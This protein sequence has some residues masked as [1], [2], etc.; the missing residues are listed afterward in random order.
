MVNDRF[1]IHSS[2]LAAAVLWLVGCAGP[3]GG[4][5]DAAPASAPEPVVTSVVAPVAEKRD[6]AVA[7][8]FGV[9]ND[10][11]YWLRDD[12]RKDPAVLK[13]LRA[14]NAYADAWFN[15][16]APLR[17]AL[18]NE[19]KAR[20]QEDDASVPVKDH[21]WWYYRRFAAGQQYGIYAR[22]RGTM[23]S[24]EQVLVD[25]NARAAGK[26]FWQLGDFAVS[27]DGRWLAVAEDTVG[28]RQYTL[29]F[30]DL[31]ED[32]WLDET[33][34]NVDPALAFASDNTT[35][36]YVLKDPVTLLPYRVMRHRL[37]TPVT[38]DTEVW[39]ERDNTFY[40]T[41]YKTKSER[42]LIIYLSSTQSTEVRFVDADQPDQ[43]PQVFMARQPDHEY[44]LDHIGDEFIVRSNWQAPNFRL[45]R[46]PVGS[47]SNPLEWR[48]LLPHRAD[49]LVEGFELFADRIA[50]SERSGGL[51]KIR[52]MPLSG[53]GMG[54]LLAAEEPTYT[55]DLDHTPDLK[56]GKL[57][58]T[59]TSL[60][61]P[62]TVYELDFASGAR[63]LLKRDPVVGSFKPEDYASEY[64]MVPARDGVQIPVSLVYRK[65][66]QR[67]G[68]HPLLQHAYGSYG[69]SRDP[70]FNAN[71]L[72]LLDRGFGFA[73]A[74]IRGGQELGRQWYENGRQLKK[75]NTFNDFV[76]V[77]DYLRKH[78]Y[79]ANDQLYAQGGSAGGLL[80]GAI[81]NQ[82]PDRYRGII[83]NVPFVDV[84]TTM[85]DESI[86]LTTGEFDE[87][88]NPKIK[89]FH[90][91]MLAYSP[92]DQVKAQDYPALYVTTGLWDSQ[93]QY[94]E[95]AKW[96]A[97]LR[98]LKTDANPLLF[99]TNME[100]G[101]GGRSGRFDRLEEVAYEYAFFLKLA[102]I[103][104]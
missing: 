84:I 80:M 70:V 5:R 73:I 28:R 86:P 62:V 23:A 19:L 65:G 2:L 92:Y 52:L 98:E 94:Y 20:I 91:Y 71:R 32:R 63:T 64:L 3:A 53:G 69:S 6:H 83:A 44:Q 48:D 77:S 46:A 39:R 89:V 14:E 24:P 81:A 45:L 57:R 51:M 13:H 35:L 40:T 34:E 16:V 33:I 41:V 82:A 100:A 1:L 79:V 18:F 36:V 61:T 47:G 60:T 56:S 96:V 74:H 8:P 78:G 4:P 15:E 54:Q 88:G 59:Y 27:P 102:G 93:V 10:P 101:H 21:G 58:Y 95:P 87:W 85:L 50:V 7:S 12:T 76:D 103:T 75:Q 67:N 72:S 11:Y 37:G 17:K 38:S 30:R 43:V 49:A 55:M 42:Y 29:R 99:R 9:R 104:N 25:G 90:D 68:R 31:V 66:W 26:G 22:R 97:R